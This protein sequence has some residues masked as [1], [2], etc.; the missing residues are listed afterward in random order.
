MAKKKMVIPRIDVPIMTTNGSMSL[1]WYLFL[2]YL[3]EKSGEGGGGTASD[4]TI[5]IMKDGV[6]VGHFTLNQADD[7]TIDFTNH[8]LV[9]EVN[10]QQG[11]VDL[12]YSDVDAL[13]DTTKYGNSVALSIDSSNFQI[14]ATLK[15][16]DGNVLNT[17]DPIDLP[18][19]SVVVSGTYD[20]TNK[21]LIF[22]LQ[23]GNTF[24]V[25]VGDLIAGLQTE[26]TSANKLS[27]DLVDDASTTHKFVSANEK[28]TW[29]AKQDA[30]SDLSTI[31]SNASAGAGA[32]TTIAGYG[33]I[34]SHNASE[35]QTAL[36]TSQ[37]AAVNAGITAEKVSIYDGYATTLAGKQDT[38]SDLETIR[39]GAALGATALQPNTAITPGTATKVTYDAS[40]RITSATSLSASDIPNLSA[41]Y[42][43]ASNPNGY[44]ANVLEAVK[45]NGNTLTITNK[46]VD[47]TMPTKLSDLTNDSGYITGITSSMVTTALGFTPYSSANPNGYQA[48]VIE[49]VKLNGIALS[50]TS[51][52]V[53]VTVPTKVSDLTN[54]TGYITGI[55]YNMVITALG[56]TP[57]SASNPSGYQANVIETV[58][59]NGTALTVTSKAVDVP[60]P[61]KTSDLTNDSGF[62]TSISSSMVVSALGYTPVNP[63]SL[64]TVATSGQYSDLSGKPTIPTVNNPTI[65]FMQGSTLV[66]TMTL[67]QSGN[68]TITFA[69]GGSGAFT[70][71]GTTITTVNGEA[72]TIAVKNHNT[73]VGALAQIKLW[74]GTKAE[75]DAQRLAETLDDN[76]LCIVKG[77]ANSFD[78]GDVVTIASQ[79]DDYGDLSSATVGQDWGSITTTP[80]TTKRMTLCMGEYTLGT[81]GEIL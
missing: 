78:W 19:E 43:L 20:S 3:L 81:Y 77:V 57:Y 27:A 17:C 79:E 50:V 60:V 24:D 44:Q 71:D 56:F 26:I 54:D 31:R 41:T 10:G 66:A 7:K 62:L 18:L 58:K 13:P 75:Y 4:A 49:T 36:S 72:K 21:K 61:T 22:T 47:I 29:N 42:Y 32:A 67:N 35:F 73:A 45:V 80:D 5:T 16:Q 23:N 65:T 55:T 68:Q 39:S 37:M 53:D 46:A 11:A 33:N 14:T 59:V 30:I 9:L 70:P 34:V 1:A 64:A 38:I 63:T 48:N 28:S 69:A 6:E 2:S 52:A 51:K 25:P 12:T 76:T 8:D 74:E 40:G 15:D